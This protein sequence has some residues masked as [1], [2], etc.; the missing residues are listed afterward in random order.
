M[1]LFP[2]LKK[3]HEMIAL[4]Y[5][6]ARLI[7]AA[8]LIIGIISPL[9]L[10]TLSEEYLKAGAPDAAYFQT[11]GALASKGQEL[12]F[13]IAMLTLGLGSLSFCYLLYHSKLVP[14]FI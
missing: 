3:H 6:G 9:L 12:T 11:L 10:I 14:R 5:V 1:L 8:L 7:E 13:Q 2:I 4:G